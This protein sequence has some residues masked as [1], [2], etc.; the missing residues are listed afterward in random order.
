MKEGDRIIEPTNA[1]I[2]HFSA[3][4]LPIFFTRDW[5]PAN[6]VSFRSQGGIWP[7]HC[8]KGTPGA[9]FPPSLHVPKGAA[10]I[11]KAT[12]RYDEAY[13]GFQGTDLAKRLKGEGVKDLFVAGVATDY[14]VMNTVIDAIDIGFKVYL[15]ADCVRGVNIR[16]TDSALAFRLI[17][18]KGA[19]RATSKRILKS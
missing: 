4:R 13:S 10:V 19:T 1:L 5:H 9:R 16:R 2:D 17:M 8:L 15:V 12:G 11:S 14:C 3:Q 18:A 6:H 7:P